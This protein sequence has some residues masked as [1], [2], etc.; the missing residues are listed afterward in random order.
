MLVFFF[1]YKNN[2]LIKEINLSSSNGSFA[3]IT[4][5]KKN[6]KKIPVARTKFIVSV[7]RDIRM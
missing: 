3:G 2:F 4:V 7:E 1:S 5:H 6:L